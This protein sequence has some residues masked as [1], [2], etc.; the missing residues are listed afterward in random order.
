MLSGEVKQRVNSGSVKKKWKGKERNKQRQAWRRLSRALQ[1]S[2]F[3]SPQ[4]RNSVQSIPHID[5]FKKSIWPLCKYYDCWSIL[6]AEA[7][8]NTFPNILSLTSSFHSLC[9][10]SERSGVGVLLERLKVT[11]GFSSLE[12]PAKHLTFQSERHRCGLI[13]A[14]L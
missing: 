1:R 3:F 13:A 12:V 4:P 9:P 5:F 8:K 10:A 7:P 6:R 14:P 11:R 2:H